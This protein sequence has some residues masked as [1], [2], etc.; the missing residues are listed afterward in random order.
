MLNR[1]GLA[2]LTIIVVGIYLFVNSTY[3]RMVELDHMDDRI[4]FGRLEV[5]R[6]A[7]YKVA[8]IEVHNR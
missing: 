6:K 3:Y 5:H 1:I 7:D 2:F 4:R 8:D